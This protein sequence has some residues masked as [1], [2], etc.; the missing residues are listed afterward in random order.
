MSESTS[1]LAPAPEEQP[2]ATADDIANAKGPADRRLRLWPAV[3]ILILQWLIIAA[4]GWIA[5]A[6]PI[7]FYGWMIGPLVGTVGLMAWWMFASRIRWADRWLGLVVF[8]AAAAATAFLS[9]TSF[10]IF[11]VWLYGLPTAIT[12]W[13]VWLVITPF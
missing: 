11:G 4:P 8:I 7:Q 2:A 5:P 10:G 1:H 13:V 9:H 12:A 3:V 6:T